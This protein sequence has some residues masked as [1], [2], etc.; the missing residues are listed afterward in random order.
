MAKKLTILERACKK[1]GQ[2]HRKEKVELTPEEIAALRA[3]RYDDILA[4][5]YTE[6]T[7]DSCKGRETCPY[8]FDAY[9]TG[10]DCLQAK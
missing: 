6:Y 8:I 3:H 2:L 4:M 10:G 9:S 1:L 5:G 7:C